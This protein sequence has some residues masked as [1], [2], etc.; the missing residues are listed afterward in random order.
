M[1]LVGWSLNEELEGMNYRC[2]NL[3]YYLNLLSIPKL[4]KALI[5]SE[6]VALF[7]TGLRGVLCKYVLV[8]WCHITGYEQVMIPRSPR[9]TRI[10][11]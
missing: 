5:S 11:I 7:A 1:M 4:A 3:H 8:S 10:I 2:Q 6:V 9:P